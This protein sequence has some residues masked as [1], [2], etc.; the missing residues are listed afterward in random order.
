MEI[1]SRENLLFVGLSATSRAI[2]EI[3][4]NSVFAISE[5]IKILYIVGSKTNFSEI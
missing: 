2:L 5:V 4:E 1:H 3:V